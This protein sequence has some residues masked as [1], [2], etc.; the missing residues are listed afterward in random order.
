MHVCELVAPRAV[1]Y[2]PGGHDSQSEA[3][4]PPNAE[5]DPGGHGVDT[6][7]PA[8]LNVPGG[9]GM[10][11]ALVVAPKA[12]DAVP[13]LHGSQS[14]WLPALNLQLKVPWPQGRGVVAHVLQNI[15]R[16]HG[17]HVVAPASG[18]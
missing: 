9:T 18:M 4:E 8:P 15:P 6:F 2:V 10:H 7:A 16:G 13:A 17:M 5:K 1:E 14:S 12:S 11:V 3:D